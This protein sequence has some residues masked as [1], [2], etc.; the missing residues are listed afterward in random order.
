MIETMNTKRTSKYIPLSWMDWFI[1]TFA[2]GMVVVNTGFWLMP[3]LPAQF[4]VS[5]SLTS[6]PFTDPNAHYLFSNYLQPA[7]FGLFGGKSII[8]Y[9]IYTALI[10]VIYFFTFSFWFIHYH[11]RLVAVDEAKLLVAVTFPVFMIPFYWIGMD[12]MTLLLMLITMILISSRW[13]FIPAV[14]LGMQHFEQGFVAFSIL[15]ATQILY[16]LQSREK[17]SGISLKQIFFVILGILAGKV[18]LFGW[19]ELNNISLL[20]SRQTYLE[21]NKELFSSMWSNSWPYIAWSLLGVG[22][23]F[24]IS[25]A[26]KV[27]PFLVSTLFV[28]FF[29]RFVNDQTRVGV[30]ILFPTL[31]YWVLMNR[32]LWSDLKQIYVIALISLYL[33]IPVVVVWGAPHGDL[34]NYDIKVAKETISGSGFNIDH[35]DWLLP[36]RA[37]PSIS[38][39]VADKVP[40]YKAINLPSQTGRIDG[41][42]RIASPELDQPG[43]LTYGPYID[44]PA[45]KYVATIKYKSDSDHLTHIGWVDVTSSQ[46]TKVLTKIDLKGTANIPGYV[47]L[48]FVLE[49][50]TEGIEVR[51]WYDAVSKV[52]L[53]SIEIRRSDIRN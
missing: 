11:G 36:F 6:N 25:K 26:K 42:K 41:D 43:F 2:F 1:T 47:E 24:V 15:G 31:F 32:R 12:G 51:Y 35:F 18:L 38:N 37:E 30:I 9:V 34:L 45:G 40:F 28:F 14:L 21:N 23:F 8:S 50:K 52:E 29:V 46:G 53:Y 44:L 19:F 10:T 20:G 22:W 5:Q 13:V 4:M 49:N 3:N 16:L 7:I 39:P 48:P 17:T 33:L 27:W